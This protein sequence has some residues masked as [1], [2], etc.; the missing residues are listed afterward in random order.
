[1]KIE[2]IER[3]KVTLVTQEGTRLKPY[4]DCCGQYW[5]NC[6][7]KEKGKLTIGNGRN[8][9]DNG[10]R[11]SESIIMR[12]NDINDVVEG[13]NIAIPWINN[14]DDARQ[15]VLLNMGFNL[16]VHGLLVWTNFLTMIKGG[17]YKKASEHMMG[18]KWAR[19][20]GPRAEYLAK[21]MET[22]QF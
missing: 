8:L 19:Q 3:L 21:V 7:C 5:R 4:L 15:Y 12:D 9:D 11:I 2:V 20:V 14:L 6:T 22:G 18:Q 17:D 10:I 13:L 16:G 1:M